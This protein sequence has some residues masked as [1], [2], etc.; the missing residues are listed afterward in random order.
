MTTPSRL[1]QRVQYARASDG[2][3]LAWAESGSGPIVVKA[4]NWLTH[5]EYEWE[6][7]VWRHW[8]RFFSEH[9]R[10][11]RYD[12]RGCGMSEWKS[13][14]LTIEQWA[15]DLTTIIE[16]ARPS[17]PVTLLGISQGQ[18]RVSRTRPSTLTAWRE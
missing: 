14:P 2:I 8:I 18:R 1:R 11:V 17:E 16:A 7:P 4:A 9:C 12:E 6:S 5:L 10:L 13:G 3:R 15:D